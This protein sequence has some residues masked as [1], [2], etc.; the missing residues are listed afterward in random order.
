LSKNAAKLSKTLLSI[1]EEE[2]ED[3]N[4]DEEIPLPNV[5]SAALEKIIGFLEHCYLDPMKYIERPLKHA[6]LDKLIIDQPWYTLFVKTIS[7][8]ISTLKEI[9]NAANY[10][11]IEPLLDLCCASFAIKIKAFE[12]AEL[13]KMFDLEIPSSSYSSSSDEEKQNQELENQWLTRLT[14]SK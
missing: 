1:L 2:D 10:M 4:D 5:S 13:R 3:N 9:L 8:D 6:S 14:R 11:T 12:P 7:E